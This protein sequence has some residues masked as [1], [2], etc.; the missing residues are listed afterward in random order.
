MVFT[1][2]HQKHEFLGIVYMK[3]MQ[4]LCAKKLQ[5]IKTLL[6]EVKQDLSKCGDTPGLW[7]GRLNLLGGKSPYID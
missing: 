2:Y 7:I 6:S 3:A 1:T 5:N 4:E